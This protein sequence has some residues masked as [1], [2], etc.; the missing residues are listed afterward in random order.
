MQR[1]VETCVAAE[2]VSS[3]SY[4]IKNNRIV[5]LCGTSTYTSVNIDIVILSCSFVRSKIFHLF[6]NWK[7]MTEWPSS[8][9]MMVQQYKCFTCMFDCI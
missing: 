3:S 4:R 1:S 5:S 9:I 8:V 6:V 7:L 2:N